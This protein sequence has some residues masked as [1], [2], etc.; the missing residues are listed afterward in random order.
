MKPGPKPPLFGGSPFLKKPDADPS[1]PAPLVT[2]SPRRRSL[3]KVQAARDV[4]ALLPE[5]EGDSLLAVLSS[6]YD[7]VLLLAALVEGLV[8]RHGPV[9]H[10]RLASLS[11]SKRCTA[12]VAGMIDSGAVKTCS[13]LLS[14]YQR[15]H[16]RA[17]FRDCRLAF[18][19]RGCRLAGSRSHCKIW[20]L[21]FAG[22]RK[23]A[24]HGSANLRSNRNVELMELV[25]DAARH[26]YLAAWLDDAVTNGQPSEESPD[27]ADEEDARDE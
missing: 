14:E 11:T 4:V 18:A 25:W 12:H 5:G 21:H 6:A 3:T 7:P 13:L 2:R 23:L 20:L 26:D 1:R 16:D 19:E 10:L 24:A 15:T 27:D 22:G 17:I 9:E 8:P